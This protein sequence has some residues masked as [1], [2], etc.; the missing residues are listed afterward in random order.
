MGISSSAWSVSAFLL[1]VTD[2][3]KNLAA[4]KK[5][6]LGLTENFSA[7]IKVGDFEIKWTIGI[8]DMEGRYGGAVPMP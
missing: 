2:Y 7:S 3:K 4:A 8:S 6:A 1:I 5:F